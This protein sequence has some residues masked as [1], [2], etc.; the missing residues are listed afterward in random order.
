MGSLARTVNRGQRK[1]LKKRIEKGRRK[2]Q[3][4]QR[5]YAMTMH[6]LELK[7][8]RGKRNDLFALSQMAESL[9]QG[10]LSLT[11]LNTWLDFCEELEGLLDGWEDQ[12]RNACMVEVSEEMLDKLID[13]AKNP[14]QRVEFVGRIFG[15]LLREVKTL[16]REIED[17][18]K[19][20]K[21]G[22][23][24]PGPPAVDAAVNAE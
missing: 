12:D 1:K 3:Q 2:H 20:K 16:K 6:K 9:N 8:I 24:P 21:D 4:K 22:D 13:H 11:E 10:S 15:Y 23:A 18:Q 14:P 19:K 17:G 5:A 7:F